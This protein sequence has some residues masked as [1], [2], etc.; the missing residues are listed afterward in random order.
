MTYIVKNAAGEDITEA[1]RKKE[2]SGG[3]IYGTELLINNVL[4]PEDQIA[5]IVITSP[6][7]DTTSNMFYVGSFI[8]QQ[9]TITFRN[10]GEIPVE[11]KSGLSV[12]L[13]ITMKYNG[14][15]IAIP[16]GI[17]AIDDLAEDY[18]K[19]NEIVCLDRAVKLKQTIDYSPCFNLL[20]VEKNGV[21]KYTAATLGTILEYICTTFNIELEEGRDTTNEDI[22]TGFYDSTISAKQWISYIAELK[23]CNV[24]MTRTGTLK[25][26]PLKPSNPITI[27][28]LESK[29]WELGEKFK[30]SRVKYEI[31]GYEN[32]DTTDRTLYIRTDNPF[33]NS[34][35][36]IDKIAE[37]VIGTEIWTVKNENFGDITMDAWDTIKFTLGDDK[38][39]TTLNDNTITFEQSLMTKIET[40]VP[41]EQQTEAVNRIEPDDK[42]TKNILKRD[43]DLINGEITTTIEKVDK[44]SSKITE[45]NE[46]ID[47]L[48]IN[49]QKS[50]NNLVRNSMFYDFEGWSNISA[51]FIG[52]GDN[53]PINPGETIP[54]GTYIPPYW[55]CTKTS[56]D[57]ENGIVYKAILGDDDTVISWGKTN[58]KYS[59]L[60][61]SFPMKSN[62]GVLSNANTKTT[63]LS[64]RAVHGI[65]DYAKSEDYENYNNNLNSSLFDILSTEEEM[66]IS[67]KTSYV[68]EKGGHFWVDIALYNDLVTNTVSPHIFSIDIQAKE[69]TNE[70]SQSGEL[71]VFKF[72]IPRSRNA[73][74]VELS[75]TAP[76]N[77]QVLWLKKFTI[78]STIDT[79]SYYMLYKY[80]T[81]TSEWETTYIEK[82][83]KDQNDKLYILS[84]QK[85]Y[86][87]G[88]FQQAGYYKGLERDNVWRTSFEPVAGS[89][90]IGMGVF[91][92]EAT[93]D[94]ELG[95]LKLEYGD[96]SEWT[97][98][99]TEVMGLTHLLDETGYKINSGDDEMRIMVDEIAQYYKD[100]KTF[101]L[102]KYEGYMKNAISETTN[103]NGL[104][105]QKFTSNN[106]T[107]YGRYIK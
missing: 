7:I 107:M 41:T 69:T 17:Y 80:N 91:G 60:E 39:Y 87:D 44:N 57:Y 2:Y 81:E 89:V 37:K 27:N 92:E 35:D 63:Y 101:W 1:I 73:I 105:T 23:G 93:V 85:I 40:K 8:S 22:V 32:G 77:T 51:E 28:A 95:D 99:R 59:N 103:V 18:Q 102:N 13:N 24:K 9:I 4:I 11:I 49:F 6:I 65:F 100:T 88:E 106:N 79:F 34:Q 21:I 33:I 56:G 58:I 54:V 97:P 25:F 42:V 48:K 12:S 67:F 94:L 98:K 10:I 38:S 50:G 15:D 47:G 16:I 96:Y 90:Q 30:I 26:V 5:K 43:I 36:I 70:Y 68:L 86:T 82:V 66:T 62:W 19:K 64:S 31:E 14:E 45:I 84:N 76:T 78:T 55:Y 29:S 75:D 46:S 83:L 71:F 52:V 72:K 61:E 104:I 20:P 53:P 3:A 74:E